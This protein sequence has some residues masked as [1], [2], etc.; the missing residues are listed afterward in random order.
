MKIWPLKGRGL[1][2]VTN[3][4]ILGP[5]Y[6]FGITTDRNFIFGARIDYDMYQPMHNKLTRKVGVVRVTRPNF[7]ISLVAPP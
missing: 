5:I 1:G 7:K 3:F 4:E 6:I 2:H